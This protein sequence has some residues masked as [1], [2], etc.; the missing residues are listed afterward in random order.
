MDTLVGILKLIPVTEM[1][2]HSRAQ[3]CA[4]LVSFIRDLQEQR[5]HRADLDL[6]QM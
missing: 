5:S 3:A 2:L 1:I 6:L 4:C